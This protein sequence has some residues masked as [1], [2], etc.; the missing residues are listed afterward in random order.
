MFN[1]DTLFLF[2][3]IFSVLTTIKNFVKIISAVSQNNPKPAFKNDTA[4]LSQGLSLTYIITYL[5][6]TFT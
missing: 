2:L 4:L 3:F 1:I 6:Q 5:I